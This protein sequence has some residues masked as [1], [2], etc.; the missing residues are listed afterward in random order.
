[1]IT[2]L[3]M[4][5]SDQYSKRNCTITYGV[6]HVHLLRRQ[7]DRNTTLKHD[8]VVMAPSRPE[9]LAPD[10]RYAAMDE[11]LLVPGTM[12]PKLNVFR[13]DLAATVGHRIFYMDLDTVVVGNIDAVASRPE[14]LVLWKHPKWGVKPKAPF[15][16]SSFILLDAGARPDIW[17]SF[18]AKSSG[19]ATR[20]RG[21]RVDDQD[22]ISYCVGPDAA[23]WTQA[24][25]VYWWVELGITLPR[26]AALVTYPGRHDPSMPRVRE[27]QPWIVQHQR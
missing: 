2:F 25:G 17:E 13:P 3:F 27:R 6:E 14:P 18:D 4:L 22:W 23:V 19:L 11:R 7:I 21:W 16:N 12:Y 10:I 15:Y 24:D 9:G 1:M 26:N 8:F 20:A 5:W